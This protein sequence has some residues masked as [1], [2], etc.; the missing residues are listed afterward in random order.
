MWCAVT[1][2]LSSEQ[3]AP[4]AHEQCPPA[5]GVDLHTL[6]HDILGVVDSNGMKG[7]RM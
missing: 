2:A 1:R 6:A 3:A 5:R 7:A 4:C